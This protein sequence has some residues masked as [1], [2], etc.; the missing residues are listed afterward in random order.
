MTKLL[1]SVAAA[2]LLVSANAAYAF[3]PVAVAGSE[4]AAT[5]IASQNQGQGQGQDQGQLQGQSSDNSVTNKSGDSRALGVALGQAATAAQGC[6]KGTKFAF[7]LVEW[8]DHSTKCALYGA[9]A[10]AEAAAGVAPSTDIANY[11]YIRANEL[12][13]R[14][15]GLSIPGN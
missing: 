14:A 8:T 2:A 15:E 5:A 4:A 10:L 1:T 3:G 9:A 7:G 13:A 6:L 11:Y 12:M